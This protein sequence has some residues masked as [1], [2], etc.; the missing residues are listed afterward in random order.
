MPY[1]SFR[2]F[3]KGTSLETFVIPEKIDAFYKA[4]VKNVETQI[5]RFLEQG[6]S[7]AEI[8]AIIK[9]QLDMMEETLCTTCPGVGE[10]QNAWLEKATEGMKVSGDQ[11]LV[12]WF[13]CVA[14]LLK[15][16]VIE[17][18]DMNGWH[19]IREVSDLQE[20]RGV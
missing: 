12:A 19:F 17:N 7:L 4:I 13:L 11:L 14:T 16:K 20:M 15:L 8:G 5:R 6:M 1:K 18:D 3:Y 9:E 2:A 10:D